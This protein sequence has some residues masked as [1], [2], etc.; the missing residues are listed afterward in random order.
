MVGIRVS[1]G[2]VWYGIVEF[3]ITLDTV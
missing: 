3:N 2:M 1:I